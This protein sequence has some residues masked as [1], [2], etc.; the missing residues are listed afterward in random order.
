M[1]KKN[2]AGMSMKGGRKDNFFFCLLEYFPNKERWFLNSLLQVKEHQEDEDDII[3]KWVKDFALKKLVLDFP[4]TL[5][6]CYGC[7]LDC[8]GLSRC[9]VEGIHRT[10]KKMDVLLLKDQEMKAKNPKRYEAARNEA[11]SVDPSKNILNIKT[12]EHILSRAFKRRIKK[13]I[14]PYW[15]RPLDFWV[16]TQYY[17]QQMELFNTS[18]DSFGTASLMILSRFNYLKRHFPK[19]LLL[20]EGNVQLALLELLKAKILTKREVKGL[21]DFKEG[22]DYRYKVIKKIEKKLNV[23]I[24]ESDLEALLHFPRAFN[25]FILA[26][27][28]QRIQM[29]KTMPLPEWAFSEKSQFVVPLFA[30][31]EKKPTKTQR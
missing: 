15:N 11:E 20:F 5:P 4:L 29:E 2:I 16:W 30:S 14:L 28:G 22:A 17:D 18:F 23:F 25:S 3:R 12:D 1:E 19:E 10:R 24:Y 6:P 21:S 8:P 7:N 9:P 31:N 26:I 13:G 27:I